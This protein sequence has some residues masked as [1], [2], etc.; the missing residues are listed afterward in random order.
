MSPAR[1]H[2]LGDDALL[3]QHL[4]EPG[5]QVQ[6]PGDEVPLGAVGDPGAQRLLGVAQHALARF[7]G[8]DV[9]PGP[10]G[11]FLQAIGE[12]DVQGLLEP[13][14][15]LDQVA[16]QEQ[17]GTD[18]VQ[19]V[20]LDLTVARGQGLV[21][22]PP[23]PDERLVGDPAEHHQLGEVAVGHREVP[24]GPERLQGVD[25]RRGQPLCFGVLAEVPREP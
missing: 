15:T 13:R 20:R 10:G 6:R 17:R 12:G 25:G 18:V 9:D 7:E 1:L 19:R 23:A 3:E 14:P 11:M 24:A 16:A 8:A 2:G 21:E 22:G 4:G 5:L